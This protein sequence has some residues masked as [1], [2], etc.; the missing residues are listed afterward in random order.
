MPGVTVATGSSWGMMRSASAYI[1]AS[2]YEGYGRTLIEAALA[3]IPM[4]TTDVGIVGDVF[5]GYQEVLSAP[6]GDPAAL[7]AHIR[8]LLDDHQARALF[9]EAAEKAARAHLAA[10][11]DPAAALRE[12][13]AQALSSRI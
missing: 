5:R 3:R 7:A 9:V 11:A 12:D 4:I 13:L 1:Q 6:P 10:N 2:A 8:G